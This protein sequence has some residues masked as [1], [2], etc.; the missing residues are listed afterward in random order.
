MGQERALRLV[1][2][3]PLDAGPITPIMRAMT[4]LPTSTNSPDDRPA[5]GKDAEQRRFA[6]CLRRMANGDERALGELY[7]ATV[8]RVYGFALRIVN[9][10][11]VAEEISSDVYMQVWRDA[12]RYD[13][14]RAKVS[15]WLLMICRSRA[16]DWLRARDPEIAHDDPTSLLSADAETD[17]AG[18]PQDLLEAL[19]DG[20][21]LREAMAALQ[22]IQRQLLSL[23]FFRGLTHQ[24]IAD[25]ARLPLGTV[26][27]HIRRALDSMRALLVAE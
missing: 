13:A 25:S 1:V 14:S 8:G 4:D 17:V 20:H 9:N 6:D 5:S 16:L 3:S 24:E 23:A 22:P 21:A 27:S 18:G 15:T 12:G 11:A 19:Q 7:D 26:K 10:A 2:S